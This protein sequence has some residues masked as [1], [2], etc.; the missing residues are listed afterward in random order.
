MGGMEIFLD[1][2]GQPSRN[3]ADNLLEQMITTALDQLIREH[4]DHL[5]QTDPDL[6]IQVPLH[7]G[8]LRFGDEMH[9]RMEVDVVVMA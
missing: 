2:P 9:S 8:V 3:L 1:L 6:E 4:G 5:G 7:G